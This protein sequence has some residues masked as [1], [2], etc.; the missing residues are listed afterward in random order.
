MVSG[1]NSKQEKWRIGVTKPADDSLAVNEELQTILPL[2]DAGMATS[3]NYRNFYYQ[4][5]KKYA[6]TIDPLSGRPV[7][8]NLLSAT[9]VA[10]NCAT[11]DAYATAFMVMGMEKAKALLK[12]HSELKAYLIYA[13]DKG[14]LQV[15]DNLTK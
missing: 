7:Q 8:H 6:H 11:A 9:V 12:R 1:K 15:W 2:T 5:G 14:Q 10:A 13:D 4:G 3:G